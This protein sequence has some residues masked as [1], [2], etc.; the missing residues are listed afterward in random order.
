MA[1]WLGLGETGQDTSRSLVPILEKLAEATSALRLSGFGVWGLVLVFWLA[2]KRLHSL[3][4][5][6]SSLPGPCEFGAC[7]FGRCF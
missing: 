7:E 5:S 2:V 6:E 3:Q 4:G 1:D